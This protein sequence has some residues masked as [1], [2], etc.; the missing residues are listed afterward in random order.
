MTAALAA[1]VGVC[2]TVAALLWFIARRRMTRHVRD[3]LETIRTGDYQQ[4]WDA[5]EH[6][7]NGGIYSLPRWL[8]MMLL[9]RPE[10][11]QGPRLI[12]EGQARV[13]GKPAS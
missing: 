2:W 13:T 8:Q 12:Q 10:R 9:A 5:A 4:V 7:A 11:R 6:L 1:M 3:Q